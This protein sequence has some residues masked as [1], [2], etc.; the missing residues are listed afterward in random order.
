M[1]GTGVVA[2]IAAGLTAVLIAGCGGSGGGGEAAQAGDIPDN[3]AYVLQ[4]PAGAGVTLKVPEGWAGTSAGGTAAFT[5]KLNRI[6]VASLATPSAPTTQSV[7]AQ[8]VAE[9]RG[10]VPGF[11]PG[12]A[13]A[14][15]RP[16]GPGVLLTYR[17]DTAP[18]PVTGKVVR[19]EFERYVFFRAGHEVVLTLSG[20]VGAD[21]VDP[22]RIVT[23]SLAWTP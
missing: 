14:V 12:A 16:I 2:T 20:P 23:D 1:R 9:L 11:E 13:S 5:D 3:Q 19:D 21:N 7:Q 6:E 17:G 10:R 8:D 22:W 18:D 4:T 15:V